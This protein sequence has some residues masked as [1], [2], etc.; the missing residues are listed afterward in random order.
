MRVGVR[1]RPLLPNE[2]AVGSEMVLKYPAEAQ[3]GESSTIPR[4]EFD[5]VVGYSAEG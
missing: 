4:K 2:Q 3:I 5:S 1:V